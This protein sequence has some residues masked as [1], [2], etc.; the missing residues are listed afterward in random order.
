M[1]PKIFARLLTSR[2]LLG[3]NRSTFGIDRIKMFSTTPEPV[4]P[5][6]TQLKLNMA[7]DMGVDSG[8][9]PIPKDRSHLLK[10]LPKTQE[11]LPKRSME[12]SYLAGIIPLSS[13]KVL[14]DKYVTFLGHVRIGRLLEDM[15]IFAV[16]VAHKHIVNPKQ[17]PNEVSPYTLVTALVDKIDFTD[18]TPKP[19]EDIKI[20]GHVS[21]VGKSS[22]EVVVWLEQR[23]HGAWHRVICISLKCFRVDVKTSNNFNYKTI[24]ERQT[25]SN[26]KYVLLKEKL[27]LVIP[28]S[29]EQK[30]IHDIYLRTVN[31]EIS[32]RNRVLPPG[33][34]WMN[35]ASISNVVFS[36]PEERNMHNTVF[37]GFIMAQAEELS[38]VLGY[39]F[40]KYRPTLKSISDIQFQRPIAVSSLIQMH[41]QVVYTQINYIQILVHVET[42]NP[43]TGKNDSTNTF[44]FTYQV[45]EMVNEVFPMT[46]HEAMMYIDGRRHFQDVMKKSP[47]I[48]PNKL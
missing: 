46:Y 25:S 40:S 3:A 8:Y 12:D 17:P 2:Y 41:A 44:H 21:W 18:F 39:M 43:I 4:Y 5:T 47:G 23:M 48:F 24:L 37:G 28:D 36:H 45:P 30:I 13:D 26:R 11:E 29:E 6:V 16:M 15:D 32:H 22:L 20:S 38:W 27:A 10:F 7:K 9:H 19:Q 34:V 14:Q 33:C 35:S 1:S 42:Y 31:K